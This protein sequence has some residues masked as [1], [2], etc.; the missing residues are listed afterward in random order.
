MPRTK[1]KFTQSDATRLF[2]AA[3]KADVDVRIEL[4][5]GTVIATIG[6]VDTARTS[7]PMSA[8]DLLHEWRRKR[9]DANKR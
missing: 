7:E 9:R 1:G 5:D 6:K 8:D 2:K 3:K 4:P